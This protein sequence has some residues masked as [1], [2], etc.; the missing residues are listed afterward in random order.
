MTDPIEVPGEAQIDL[1]APA[2]GDVSGSSSTASSY[3]PWWRIGDFGVLGLWIAVVSFTIQYHEKW[4]D[5]AQAWL[6][7]RDLSLRAIWF[8]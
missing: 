2:S 1:A 3:S 6:I 7:A 5:E 8:H 4:A